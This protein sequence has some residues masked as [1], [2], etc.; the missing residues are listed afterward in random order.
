MK[1][2]RFRTTY[3]VLL[4]VFLFT[5]LLTLPT[6]ASGPVTGSYPVVWIR[7]S[8]T[9]NSTTVW[10]RDTLQQG[11]NEM[12]TF[13]RNLSYGQLEVPIT[14]REAAL[15]N[16]V[17]HYWHTCPGDPA[18]KCQE[19]VVE[20]AAA[21][22]IADGSSFAGVKTVMIINPCG[23]ET[24]FTEPGDVHITGTGFDVWVHQTMDF[25]CG[26]SNPNPPGPSGVWWSSWAHELG[27]T[28]Q[29][30]GHNLFDHPAGYASGYD[31]MD[32]CYPCHDSVY[33]LSGNPIVGN[34]GRTSFPGWLPT[35]KVTVVPR[36]PSG[37]I[38]TTVVLEPLSKADPG[39]TVAPRG[40]KIPINDDHYYIVEARRRVRADSVDAH[41]GIMDEGVHIL[42]VVESRNPPVR[43][44]NACDST[45]TGGCLTG[46]SDP[47]YG[48]CLSASG[49]WP[50][51]PGYCW[52]FVLF[53]AGQQYYD[54]VNNIRVRVDSVVG[55]AFSVTVT[56]GVPPGHP[57][58]MM[59]PWL[60]APMNTWETIDIW[61]DSSCNG[62][63][64]TVGAAGLRYGRRSDGTVIGNGD[65]PC[66][67]H[68]NRIYAH[69][70]NGG[71]ATANAISVHFYVTDPLGVGIRGAS[72]WSLV[73]TATIPTLAPGATRDV[74]VNW[75]P[76]VTLTPAQIS[77]RHF[78]FHSCVQVKMDAVAGELVL[79]NQDGDGEQENFDNFEAVRDPITS[80]FHLPEQSFFLANPKFHDNPTGGMAPSGSASGEKLFKLRVDSLL[81]TGWGYEVAGGNLEQV[82]A[83]NEVRNIP[84]KITVPD[85]TDIGHTY[86][87]KVTAFT[88]MTMV[89]PLAPASDAAHHLHYG[90]EHVAGV[91]LAAQ[92][93]DPS[94]ITITAEFKCPD[95]GATLTH[96]PPATL[97]VKGKLEPARNNV[98]IAID[99]TPPGGG[100]VQTHLAH[101][102]SAGEFEDTLS[103]PAP[104][105]WK[106]RAFWQGSLDLAGAVSDEQTVEARDCKKQP[107]EQAPTRPVPQ[108]TLPP[109]STILVPDNAFPGG[110][111]T[112]VVIG[113]DDKPVPNTP[114]RIDGGVPAVLTG[115]VIGEEL[116][117][118]AEKKPPCGTPGA[119][120]RPECALPKGAPPQLP[121]VQAPGDCAS[122][123]RQAQAIVSR[124]ENV[125]LD[126]ILIGLSQPSELVGP[127]DVR[128]G[129]TEQ[130][131]E[132]ANQPS[133]AP[134]LNAAGGG[135]WTDANG[136]FA[137]CVKP[138]AKK[139]TAQS[140]CPLCPPAPAIKSDVAVVNT[141]K[142]GGAKTAPPSFFQ[143]NDKV[144]L[145]GLLRQPTME[146]GGQ[147]WLLPA[148][149]AISADGK[150]VLTAFKT[151][152]NLQPG[153]VNFSFF[154]SH[155]AKQSFTGGV[156]K[157][158]GASIDRNQLRSSEGA[159][160]NYELTFSPEMAGKQLCVEVSTT[161]PIVLTQPP[162]AQF[163][164]NGDGHASIQGKIRATQVAPG[165]AVPFAIR[166]SVFDCATGHH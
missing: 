118:T 21:R 32:S 39:A 55:D 129:G 158:V 105:T 64:D 113:P 4:F 5:P 1:T 122:L 89:N 22:V 135:V 126:H 127:S 95:P 31:L 156:F 152:R 24:D 148:V 49:R 27:H 35:S 58:M 14:V 92:T 26:S 96:V 48:S 53:H 160:F 94:K 19:H 42:D 80:H 134:W 145:I 91:M 45:V 142:E 131:R 106:I 108:Q 51:Y 141:A 41:P 138:D 165:T 83:A 153:A 161:G 15:P 16:N 73:G 84:V 72:G 34:M 155:G 139:L 77:E 115:E 60:T 98:I 117:K 146:Q 102:N 114:V 17:A 46:E 54:S 76:A 11:A 71:D 23:I 159:A 3:A 154:D 123:L 128:A 61:V 28:I 78:N 151:P 136:R 20:D 47:R 52:P 100:A 67:N 132:A 97:H 166:L 103:G 70:R 18:H 13:F 86:L 30:H 62:Y 109:G 143:P 12:T 66:A 79:S 125:D 163:S 99:Y 36:P 82:L 164:V 57:D 120:N 75:T 112:G 44:I 63:E 104:G 81:P 9:D 10:T 88:P 6:F 133:T 38:G 116:P 68:E 107:Q 37:A 137:M 124:K 90:F 110:V 33:A 29:L 40:I 85:G 157:I 56:R 140:G 111:L 149:Q 130:V 65:D 162:P 59:I 50:T 101:T 150:Q 8:Y 2:S 119:A 121:A 69:V 74:Y 87:L 7:V 43:L 93:V 144:N 25:E 147:T